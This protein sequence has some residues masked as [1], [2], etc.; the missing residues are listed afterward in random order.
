MSSDTPTIVIRASSRPSLRLREL[1]DY[2]ELVYFLVWREF[3]LRYKQTIL[4][5]VWVVVQPLLMMAIYTVIFGYLAKIPSDGIP[6]SVFVMAGVIAWQFFTAGIS[7]GA[8][9]MVGNAYLITKIYFPRLIIPISGSII[10]VVDVCVTLALMLVFMLVQGVRP[11]PA[12]AAL[13][14]VLLV[15]TVVVLGVGVWLAA[16]NVRY[17]DVSSF[18]PYATQIWM[19]ASPVVYPASLVPEQYRALYGLNPMV[20]V[21]EG[22][23]W[24]LF[25]G[26][27]AP[28]S[29][30]AISAAEGV[31]LLVTGAYYFRLLEKT[32]ADEV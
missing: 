22:M 24:A 29:L 1:W 30:L 7:R 20:G 13:P 10:G 16:L 31:V 18:L 17:R 6:Y 25:S 5:V 9:S 8:S 32:F 2:R 4:G 15:A 23:R 27:E 26:Y 19:F 3:K 28:L 21:V 11:G 12:I 14:L